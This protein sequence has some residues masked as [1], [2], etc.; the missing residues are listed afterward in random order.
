MKIMAKSTLSEAKHILIDV[1]K[2][3]K[4][5][6]EVAVAIILPLKDNDMAILD[7][8]KWIHHNHPTE[9]EIMARLIK[10]AES[11]TSTD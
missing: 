11:S 1:L 8:A 9:D 2:M 6:V 4:I 5:P 10:E 3:Q 7:W